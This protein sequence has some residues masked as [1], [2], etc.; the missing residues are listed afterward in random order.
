MA[1]TDWLDWVADSMPQW[2]FRRCTICLEDEATAAYELTYGDDCTGWLPVC[3]RCQSEEQGLAPWWW[4]VA[5]AGGDL[6]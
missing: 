6:E 4:T 5:I 1:A 2:G 3:D